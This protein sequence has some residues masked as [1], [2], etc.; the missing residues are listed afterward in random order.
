MRWRHLAVGMLSALAL[1]GCPSEFGKDGRVSK[2]AHKD[3]M[4]ITRR[5]CS[6][7]ELWEVCKGPNKDPDKCHECGG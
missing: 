7:Q 3:A 4:G 6:E 5:I 1:T 2:A